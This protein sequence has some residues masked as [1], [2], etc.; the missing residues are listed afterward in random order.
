MSD[1]YLTVK[2]WE[3]FSKGKGYK[4]T[5]FLKA[6]GAAERAA[7]DGPMDQLKVLFDLE[8]K[9]QALYKLHKGDKKLESYLEDVYKQLKKYRHDAE[10]RVDKMAKKDEK[11]GL[12]ND[13]PVLLQHKMIPLLRQMRKGVTMNALIGLQDK[14]AVV[15]LQKN[16]ISNSRREL[17]QKWLGV[18][19]GVRYIAGEC[20][21]ENEM[22]T[23]VVQA[24]AAGLAKKL[25]AALLAQTE[26]RLKV[27]VRGLDPNDVDED[28]GDGD[29]I[30]EVEGSDDEG[31]EGGGEVT[32]TTATTGGDTND[33]DADDGDEA[34]EDEA[35]E[36]AEEDAPVENDARRRYEALLAKLEPEALAALKAQHPEATKIRA[37]GDFAREKA[38]SGNYAAAMTA[39]VQWARLLGITLP[40]TATTPPPTPPQPPTVD[41][42]AAFNARLAALTP[43]VKEG[44]A[45]GGEAALALKLKV[46]EAGMFARKKD[47]EAA[48]KLLDEVEALLGGAPQDS[49]HKEPERQDAGPAAGGKVAFTQA[50]LQ[51]DAM[52]KRMQSE[53]RKLEAAVLEQCKDEL[54][55]MTIATN[56]KDV[57]SVLEILDERLID[58]LDDALNA[59]DP[60]ARTQLQNEAREIVGE[61]LDYVKADDML[62]SID[63]NGFMPMGL[64]PA[65]NQ[66]LQGIDQQLRAAA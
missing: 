63:D 33:D 41:P 57:Y 13:S 17:L 8:E 21:F 50:R 55:F 36:K 48:H 20:I 27:R 22:H 53:L 44:L 42:G 65:L 59:A 32:P 29:D 46:S 15:L 19:S 58:T 28:A 62:Q 26:L 12:D 4:D 6:L 43:R 49:Q 9:G 66:C 16:T 35:E 5:E 34:D 7:N 18:T 10:K 60:A 40:P 39:L 11:E 23:F 37:V 2:E 1:K 24:Q 64:V 3:K 51:W 14:D 38:A 25:K 47:F 30:D 54:D 45:A 56:I 31:E 61:Y 52:R